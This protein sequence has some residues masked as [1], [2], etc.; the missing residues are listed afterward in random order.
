MNKLTV[1][2]DRAL[3]RAM[4]LAS[5][6]SD[7]LRHAGSNLR[8]MGPHATDWIKTGAALGA[9]K[10]GGKVATRFA[11]R[12]PAVTVAAAAIGVGLIGY[13]LYR[14]RQRDQHPLNGQAQRMSPNRSTSTTVDETSDIGSDA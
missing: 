3:E 9:V 2:T 14:K 7:S 11:R 4:D 13:A 8:H 10:S 5:N 12:N 6:A 1:I